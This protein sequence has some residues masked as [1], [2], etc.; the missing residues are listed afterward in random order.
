MA[1]GTATVGPDSDSDGAVRKPLRSW[2]HRSLRG[3]GRAGAARRSSGGRR[4]RAPRSF[5]RRQQLGDRD[6]HVRPGLRARRAQHRA[7]PG[8]SH[9]AGEVDIAGLDLGADLHEHPVRQPSARQSDAPRESA[10]RSRP[11]DSR[12][13]PMVVRQ[14]SRATTSRSMVIRGACGRATACRRRPRKRARNSAEELHQRPAAAGVVGGDQTPSTSDTVRALDRTARPP[15]PH[16]RGGV[17]E[18]AGRPARP[19]GRPTGR[20]A[21]GI[22]GD[23]GAPCGEPRSR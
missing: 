11:M 2:G 18:L 6:G 21:W 14:V 3:P 19:A 5:G 15:A 22:D 17:P 16:G 9:G 7:E 13:P 10:S 20:S 8:V 23:T 12:V 1:S 4:R